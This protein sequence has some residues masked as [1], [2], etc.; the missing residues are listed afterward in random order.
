M[1]VKF[2]N[3]ANLTIRHSVGLIYDDSYGAGIIVKELMK[4]FKDRPMY[5]VVFTDLND[6]RVKKFF[7]S[8][9]EFD[10]E[11]RDVLGSVKTIK[12]GRDSN[13]FNG[14]LFAHI[15]MDGIEDV[16]KELALIV[17]ELEKDSLVIYDGMFLFLK[18][19][20]EQT[21]FD[22]FER[23]V[24]SLDEFRGLT[25][26]PM[27]SSGIDNTISYIFDVMARV[28]K[29]EMSVYST[30]REYEVEILHSIFPKLF[31]IL[32]FKIIQGNILEL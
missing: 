31:P 12:I 26:I 10:P 1:F 2:R 16:F 18:I 3:F 27:L 32:A 25:L 5:Y 4:I 28:R 17:N 7:D 6:R 29:S 19:C 11:L 24:S 20:G 9:S 23:Y 21:F 22:N 13:T 30:R 8:L 14:N 15:E